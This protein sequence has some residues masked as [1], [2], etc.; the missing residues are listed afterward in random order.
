MHIA[1]DD[2]ALKVVLKQKFQVNLSVKLL[3]HITCLL[4]RQNC[5]ERYCTQYDTREKEQ[6]IPELVK[7]QTLYFNAQGNY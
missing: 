6:K 2:L 1:F 7:S 4:T 5:K 3:S